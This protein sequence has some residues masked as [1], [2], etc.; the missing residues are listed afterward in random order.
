MIKSEEE[1]QFVYDLL[2]NTSD[3]RDGWIGLCRKADNKSYWLDGR[4][5][6]GNYQKWNDSKPSNGVTEDC[7]RIIGGNYGNK[8]KGKW[9]DTPC[10]RSSPVAICH[11]P[12]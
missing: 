7:G 2:T 11:W 6:E 3:A 4:L 10:S 8:E 9:N 12:I 5:E 1:N